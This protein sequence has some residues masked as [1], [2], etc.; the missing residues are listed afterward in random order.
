LIAALGGIGLV[1]I[2]ILIL[3]VLAILYLASWFPSVGRGYYRSLG[4][5]KDAHLAPS[6]VGVFRL[7]GALDHWLA[8]KGGLAMRPMSREPAPHGEPVV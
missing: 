7:V 8:V 2:I 5:K 3:V 6:R 1:G 4:N